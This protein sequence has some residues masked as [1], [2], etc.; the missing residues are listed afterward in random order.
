M[1]LLDCN[2]KIILNFRHVDVSLP[3]VLQGGSC[4][5]SRW[6]ATHRSWLIQGMQVEAMMEHPHFASKCMQIRSDVEFI[7]SEKISIVFYIWQ[8]ELDLPS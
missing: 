6:W 5:R 8:K 1:E 4:K 3:Y 7:S 2:K